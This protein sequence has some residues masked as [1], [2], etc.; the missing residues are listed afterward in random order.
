MPR[1]LRPQVAGG[2]YHVIARGVAGA[3]SGHLFVDRFW[4]RLIEDDDYLEKV[5]HYVFEN[6]VKVGLCD[7]AADWRWS[8]G[9][10]H[11]AL[12]GTA[13]RV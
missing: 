5:C 3:P 6:P 2:F 10:T 13:S 11:Q 4:S 1:A 8:G 9:A 12:F 7:G